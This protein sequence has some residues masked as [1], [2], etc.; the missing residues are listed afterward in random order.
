MKKYLPLGLLVIV[1]GLVFIGIKYIPQL[2]QQ[3]DV[4][5][6][7][8]T[9]SHI[10]KESVLEKHILPP[11]EESSSF[12]K[13]SG[14]LSQPDVCP[15]LPGYQLTIPVGYQLVS[16]QCVATP[17]VC[18]NINGIQTTVPNG[19]QLVGGQCTCLHPGTP[20]CGLVQPPQPPVNLCSGV[21]QPITSTVTFGP[22]SGTYSAGSP[23]KT[24][25][26]YTLKAN[27]PVTVFK[28]TAEP[29][30]TTTSSYSTTNPPATLYHFYDGTT[31]IGSSSTGSIS[32]PSSNG[33][34]Q[35]A[36][37]TTKAIT[38]KVDLTPQTVDQ[39]LHVKLVPFGFPIGNPSFPFTTTS[40][41]FPFGPWFKIVAGGAKV[42]L[43]SGSHTAFSGG[44]MNDVWST[45]DMI[46]WTLVSP[47]VSNTSKWSQRIT[48]GL[49]SSTFFKNK[50]WVI[51]GVDSNSNGKNDIWYS[52]DG[53]NWAMATSNPGWG[54]RIV[55]PVVFN[56]KLWVIGGIN[57]NGSSY[58]D[59]W[60]SPDG[61]TWT[62]V[63]SNIPLGARSMTN[64]VV[65]NNK[66]WIMGGW[67]GQPVPQND[68]WSSQDGITWTQATAHAPWGER[69]AHSTIVFNNRLWVL[70]GASM[71][72]DY[73][74][75]WSS[76]DG[77][78]WVQHTAN[79]GWS[80]RR[81]HNTLVFGNKMYVLGADGGGSPGNEVWS[82]IDGTN[83]TKITSPIP[84]STRAW[85]Q[86][87]VAK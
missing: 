57:T 24:F 17:D 82:S 18:P 68:V 10:A 52:P 53:V 36:T 9:L 2:T 22:Q 75:V 5:R 19:Y 27:C 64:P 67:D 83:W 51:G 84:W 28:L 38:V 71:A 46:N 32:T 76:P 16:G 79:A 39:T 70:G 80:A 74:D 43:L 14:P 1:A 77:I 56:N 11:P 61:I 69:S 41:Q 50:L 7:E 78:N 13:L 87:I 73:N 25:G 6:S 29:A 58:N 81:G 47:N 31:L 3:A 55:E 30:W 65:F 72:N 48:Y 15:N 42:Y 40:S 59:A 35:L 33:Y 4:I 21:A 8:R 45:T 66:L 23:G 20:S 37:G 44:Y 49:G 34:F 60:S 54:S 26:V 62:Q 63:A 86:T 12:E 85:A